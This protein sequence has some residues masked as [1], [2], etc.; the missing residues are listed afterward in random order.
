M[1]SSK[2]R[3]WH[4]WLRLS[5]RSHESWAGLRA[6]PF[7]VLS[8]AAYPMIRICL[9]LST[10][11][12]LTAC[13]TS[14]PTEPV[15]HRYDFKHPAMGTLFAISL[16]AVDQ[17]QAEAAA[18]AAFK[19][20][21][22][23]EDVMSDY[24]ADSELMR[25]C[26]QPFGHPVPISA[27]LFDVLWQAQDM[28]RRSDGAFDVTIG[29]CVR[30]WRFS[31]K[32]KTLP[33]PAEI[34]TARAAVGWRKLRL[35]RSAR[36]AT[37]LTPNMRLDLGSIGK[38]YSADQALKVLQQRGITRA[39]V[40]GSGDIAVGDPPP[41]E[42]G[43]NVGISSIDSET[44]DAVRAIRLHNC[45]IST[46]GDTQ[47]FVEISGVRYSHIVDPITGLGLT[48]RIQATIIGPTPLEAPKS[49]WCSKMTAAPLTVA[50]TRAPRPDS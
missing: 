33:T 3:Q 32:R 39:F 10:V 35:D 23:L 7:S 30:L 11:F 45:G 12:V 4:P 27:D 43:W 41:H 20:V 46:S 6:G 18:D 40:A 8:H 25:L 19:R 1:T 38:G 16:F 36:T 50:L 24:Q 37:L 28:S 22:A 34:E 44:N 42:Q 5:S 14:A 49:Q 2:T 21:D 31:R 26:D 47:Q 9:L 29:P 15:L 17:D 48:N 13:H